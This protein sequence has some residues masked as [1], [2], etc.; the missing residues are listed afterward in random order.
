MESR[1]ERVS[2][3]EADVE[4]AMTF[5][6]I[7]TTEMGLGNMA[8][9]ASLVDKARQAYGAVT[10]LLAEMPEAE[11]QQRLREKQQALDAELREAARR[12]RHYEEQD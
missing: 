12:K 7:A 3:I 9:A 11:D 2:L 4:A 1:R 6:R 5:L 10:K 8:R